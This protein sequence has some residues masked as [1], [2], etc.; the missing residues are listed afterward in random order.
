MSDR[1]ISLFEKMAS[2]FNKLFIIEGTS[3]RSKGEKD[4]YTYGKQ[5]C[6]T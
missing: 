6:N 2:G 1:L 3:S 5:R 4:V